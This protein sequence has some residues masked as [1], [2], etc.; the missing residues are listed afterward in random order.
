MLEQQRDALRPQPLDLEEFQRGRRELLQQQIAALAGTA[1]HDFFQ[2]DREAF[3]DAGDVGDL[4]LRVFEDVFDPFGMA[5]DSGCAVAVAADAERIFAGDLHQIG[6]FPE[7]AGYLL[8]F[9]PIYTIPYFSVGP[10]PAPCPD[11]HKADR[12]R[13]RNQRDSDG[14]RAALRWA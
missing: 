12:R 13:T 9:H 10:P 14:T 4:A 2:N 7:D 6:G 11:R 3:A 1:S 5:F 8:V